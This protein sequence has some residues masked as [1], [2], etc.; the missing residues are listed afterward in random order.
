MNWK[1]E[2]QNCIDNKDWDRAL[3]MM[4]DVLVREN[5]SID[6]YL[7]YTYLLQMISYRSDKELEERSCIE[8]M[9]YP[10]FLAAMERYSENAEYL[11]WQ[12]LMAYWTEWS[13][14]MDTPDVVDMMMK[15]HKIE[16]D[17]NLYKF[18]V[19]CL[20]E[21]IEDRV[22]CRAFAKEILADEELLNGILSKGPVGQHVYVFFQ[23]ETVF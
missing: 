5:Y 9:I 20:P 16:P 21:N 8:D 4:P 10:I 14:Q 19:F 7:N 6:A 18:A 1:E 23:N 22:S 2:L 12:G 13:F 3:L 17:N 15:A 11:F